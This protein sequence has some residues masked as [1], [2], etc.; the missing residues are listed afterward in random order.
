MLSESSRLIPVGFSMGSM[1]SQLVWLRHPD[2]VEGLVLCATA[3]MFGRAACER[4]AAGLFAALLETFS[5]QPRREA[6]TPPAEI[7]EAGMHDYRWAVGQFRATTS[8]NMLRALAE[9]MRF[10][11]RTWIADIDVPTA[12]VIP[13]R[14]RA[15]S[16]RHQHWVARQIP[17]AHAVTIDAGH[18][19]CTLQAEAFLPGLRSAVESVTSRTTSTRARVAAPTG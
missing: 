6:P 9:M 1:V 4:L 10:D 3:A 13:Q 16:P 2:R 11:S 8:G 12:L 15:I 14:D 7:I 17:E 5:P 19:C 18:A